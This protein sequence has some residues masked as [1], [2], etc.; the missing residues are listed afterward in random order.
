M[1]DLRDK[2]QAAALKSNIHAVFESAP[3]KEVMEFLEQT[4]CWYQSCLVPG[5]PDMTLI[6]DGKRQ[7]LATIKTIMRLN[8]DQISGLVRAKEGD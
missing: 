3:G 8:A 6:N 5:D 4:C 2:D 7:V 1:I